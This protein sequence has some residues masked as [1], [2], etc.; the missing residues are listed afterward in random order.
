MLLDLSNS[1]D[2]NKSETYLSKLIERGAKIELKEI[3]PSRS[4]SQNSYIHACFSMISIE[5]GYTLEEIKVLLKQTYG[6]DLVY[7]KNN[8]KFIRSTR[9]LDSSQMSKFIDWIRHF[10][11]EQI[12]LYIPTPEEY[13]EN[14]FEIE[15]HIR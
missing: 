8:Q 2:K 10:S 11:S 5:T 15:K 13:I 4:T 6:S 3:K 1:L 14:K 12:G 7:V 9:D